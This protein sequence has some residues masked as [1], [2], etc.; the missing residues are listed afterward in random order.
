[1]LSP[2]ALIGFVLALATTLIYGIVVRGP[3]THANLW[4]SVRDYSRTE[5]GYVTSEPGP[6]LASLPVVAPITPSTTPTATPAPT[7]VPADVSFS[8]DV[9]PLFRANCQACHGASVS[10]K[11]ISLASYQ[12]TT[13]TKA[14]AS[15]F[16]PGKPE[17]SLLMD[18]LLNRK[19]VQ[20][21]PLGP[22]PPE[23]VKLIEEWIK[24]GG[25][26]N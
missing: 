24:Q 21:P 15:L 7:P 25:K 10:F 12:T 20:M 8:K 13:D 5:I 19:G 14:H 17:E 22:L 16:V 3:D 4:N 18:V 23:K 11:G 26:E 6:P 1:M 2:L 9:L